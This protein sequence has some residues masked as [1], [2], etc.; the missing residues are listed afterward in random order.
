LKVVPS[1]GWRY[2]ARVILRAYDRERDRENARRIWH[3]IG[4]LEPEKPEGFDLTV[5]ACRA[6]VAEIDGEAECLVLSAPG[7]LRYQGSELAFSG[8]ASVATS[9][10]AR[11]QGVAARLTARSIAQDAADGAAVSGLGIFDQGFYDRLGYGCGGYEHWHSIDPL[12]LR[13]SRRPR[14]PK[15]L[16][17]A[18]WRVIH[19]A[20]LARTRRH[21]GLVFTPPEVTQATLMWIRDGFG[22]GYY[23]GADLTHHM[24]A[25]HE[26]EGHGAY[27][28]HWLCYRTADQLFELLGLLRNLGDQVVLVRLRE[29]P[30]IQLQD[31]IERP[32]RG[33]RERESGRFET[34]N[35]ARAY[36][37]MR[38]CDLSV[39]LSS[40]RLSVGDLSFNLRL[41]DP[42]ESLL[43]D[44]SPWRGVGG[45]YVVTLADP[46]GVEAGTNAALPT[47]EAEVGAFTR[48]WLGV[49]PATGLAAT[50]QLRGPA[51]LLAELD[52]RL[53]LPQP[54]P[55]WDF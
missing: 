50:D 16:G 39:C 36:W 15:R 38:I 9:P 5:S 12:R 13:V 42:I 33:Y 23:E 45:D 52:D 28:V 43:D 20:R 27:V 34:R 21:G 29:P 30:A 53:C 14:I 40:T 6:L 24:W 19:K 11:R 8:V 26:R 44:D 4:W 10:V 25:S 32:F 54:R 37:Q 49:L 48:L 46:S 51:N 41:H 22:L 17:P 18:D 7:M 3:E 1:D 47:L 2:P 35:T 31:L 55:D